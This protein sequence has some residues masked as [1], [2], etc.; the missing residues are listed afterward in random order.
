MGFFIALCRARPA[1]AIFF[2]DGFA[3]C[4]ARPRR[5]VI[6]RR[7]SPLTAAAMRRRWAPLHF[8]YFFICEPCRDEL[9]DFHFRAAW[10]RFYA[11]HGFRRRQFSRWLIHEAA[12]FIWLNIASRLCRSS[13][14]TTLLYYIFNIRQ[15][16]QAVIY[17]LKWF[18]IMSLSPSILRVSVS[19][20]EFHA[21]IIFQ[22]CP[23]I[24][25]SFHFQPAFAI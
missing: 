22:A 25:F 18:F 19:S 17:F 13:V 6:A 15:T 8:R 11:S 12:V 2:A 16:E 24:A 14:I 5:R 3:F 7:F 20:R 10:I 21:T 9:A 1:A 23:D 4:R